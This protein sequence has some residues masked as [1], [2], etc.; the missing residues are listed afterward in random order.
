MS[1]SD[2]FWFSQVSSL[3]NNCAQ[4]QDYGG[5]IVDE[6]CQ[7]IGNVESLEEWKSYVSKNVSANPESGRILYG[8]VEIEDITT[9]E[10]V[11]AM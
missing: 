4:S 5:D 11:D 6:D 7:I 2:N 9:D 3:D 8:N 1:E 10:E